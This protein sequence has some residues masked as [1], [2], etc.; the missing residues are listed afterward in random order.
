MKKDYSPIILFIIVVLFMFTSKMIFAGNGKL[1]GRVIDES[2]GEALPSANVIITHRILSNGKETS[3]AA[4]IGSSTDLDGYYV[5]LNVP[6]GNYIVKASM[7]GYTSITQK[8]INV[9]SDRTINIDFELPTTSIEIEQITVLAEKEIIKDDVSA[10]QEIISTDRIDEM[11]V[12]RVDEFISRLKGIELTSG[13]DGVG[14]SIRGGSIR[15]TDVRLDGLSLQDPRSENS[16]LG[17][18]SSTIE[19]VQVLTG[20]FEAKYGYIRSGLLNVSTKKG[21][22]ERFTVTLKANVTPAGQ[23]RFF[24]S[25]PYSDDSWIYRVFAGEYAMNGTVGDTTV[26]EDLRFFTGWSDPRSGGKD[27]RGLDSLQKLQLWK[28]QHPQYPVANKPEYYIEGAITGPIPGE[29]IPLWG[30][31]AKHTTFMVGGRYQN[32]QFAFPLGPR[33]NY[34]YVDWNGQLKLTTTLPNNMRLSVNGMLATINS[35]TGGLTANYGGSLT[36]ASSSFSYLSSTEASVRQQARLLNG[37]FKSSLFNLSRLQFLEQKYM[38]G[39]IKFTNPVSENAFY[40]LEFQV[41]H[42]YQEL[43]PFA[44]DTSNASNYVYF[45]TDEGETKRFNV[46]NYGSPNASTNFGFDLLG[47]FEMFGG[48]QRIDSSSSTVFNLKGDL[49]MQLGRHNQVEAGFSARL[50]DIF[51]YSGTWLQAEKSFTPD[52][53]QYYNAYPLEAAFYAQ[54]KLEFEGMILNVG[55]RFELFSPNKRGFQVSH[56]LDDDY[57]KLLSDIY[58]NLPGEAFSYER[59]EAYRKVLEDPPGWPREE[60]KIQFNISPRLGVA[61]PI[62]SS[63]KMYFNYGHYY[64]R[65]ALSFMYNSYIVQG[66]VTVPTP[67]LDMPRTVS[68]EFGYEQI[69]WWD[70]LL[71]VTAYYKDVSNTPLGRQYVS[72]YGD[73][74]VTEYTPDAFSDTRGLEIRFARNVG[75]FVT[76]NAMAEYVLASWGQTGL[77]RVY[78][79]RLEARDSEIRSA[80]VVTTEARPKANINLSFHTPYDF[81]PE[82]LGVNWF[83]G[84]FANFFFE[85]RDGGEQLFN[86][87]ETNPKD[88]IY[89]DRVNYWNVDFRGSKAF[90]TSLGSLEFILTISNLFDNKFLT[91]GNMSQ[92]QYKD[93]KESL[94]LPHEE[95]ENKGSDKWGEYDKEHIDVGWWKFP[96]FLNTRKVTFGVKLS[97]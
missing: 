79:N 86:P 48:L 36:D 56:P 28:L 63:S 19:E 8:G 40:T 50:H 65:P 59:W 16:Y 93:Y 80:N 30:D 42:T 1:T 10:T 67:D 83:G 33:S 7:V 53:W 69:L 61:F 73:N 32:S 76:F 18:N 78:E 25:S 96:L 22:R 23:K 44:M 34:N 24:E 20:G 55:A 74:N 37:N 89:V 84:L 88:Y 97:L 68:Y 82:W 87:E 11:P 4:P 57:R 66:G 39:G 52:T 46:P 41:G 3:L 92:D 26:P 29:S 27:G 5:I 91:V 21:E 71:N 35:V 12:L 31:F 94:K 75:R 58:N 77:G 6:V 43:E 72:Y 85:W 70:M 90:T 60:N 51:V 62:S 13:S 14:L 9:S 15:E 47:T 49:T 95:G 81:G 45:E 64:Q 2:T 54:D 17:F 38:V